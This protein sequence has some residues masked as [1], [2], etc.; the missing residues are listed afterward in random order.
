ML[1]ATHLI[2]E[3]KTADRLLLHQG[4]A[5]FDGSIATFMQAAQGG[6]FQTEVLRQL[7]RGGGA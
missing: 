6:D 3:V 2:E 7:E 1:W 4:S 5:R